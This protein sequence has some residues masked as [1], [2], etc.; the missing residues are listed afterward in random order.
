MWPESR[1]KF[2][3]SLLA[4][5]GRLQRLW[6]ILFYKNKTESLS[7]LLIQSFIVSW[8]ILNPWVNM[9]LQITL[10]TLPQFSNCHMYLWQVDQLAQVIV[11]YFMF[12]PNNIVHFFL[13][14]EKWENSIRN[15]SS[16]V[17]METVMCYILTFYFSSISGCLPSSMMQKASWLA[18]VSWPGIA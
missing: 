5:G 3:E 2:S 1:D 13:R 14:S 11:A 7:L 17:L 9:R 4:P 10:K 8:L 16:L 6:C 18:V 12:H 15:Q